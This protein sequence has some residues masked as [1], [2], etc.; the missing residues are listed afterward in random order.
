V[1]LHHGTEETAF[2]VGFWRVFDASRARFDVRTARKTAT[3]G[4]LTLSLHVV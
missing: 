1:S 3:W 2:F 4:L